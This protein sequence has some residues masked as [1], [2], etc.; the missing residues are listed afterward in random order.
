[1]PFAQDSPLLGS[2]GAQAQ[3]GQVV[4]IPH[5]RALLAVGTT[6]FIIPFGIFTWFAYRYQLVDLRVYRLAASHWWHTGELYESKYFILDHLWL[7][8]TYPPIAAILFVPTLAFRE[9]V[10]QVLYVVAT[11]GALGLTTGLFL[12]QLPVK[13]TRGSTAAILL[14]TLALTAGFE[15]LRDT[16]KL[17]QIN[18]FLML[19]VTADIMVRV[20]RWPRGLLIGLAAAIKL[21]P[22]GFVLL[23][24]VRK[25]WRTAFTIAVSTVVFTAIGWLVAPRESRLY[26]FDSLSD[27]SRIGAPY[28]VGNE[29]IRGALSRTG[30]GHAAATGCWLLLS[31][32][33][34]AVAIV[35]MRNLLARGSLIG[36]TLANAAAV[37]LISPV[38]WSHHHVWITP[39]IATLTVLTWLNGPNSRNIAVVTA[40]AIIFAIGFHKLLPAQ[41]GG[42]LGWAWWQQILGASYTFVGVAFLAWAALLPAIS[43]I[44]R[45]PS[46]PTTQ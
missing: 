13:F 18:V 41:A 9:N 2:A 32:I 4:E 12:R 7:Y 42:E 10:V 22:A 37:L 15:P 29:S 43:P 8:F 20:P 24:L 6:L 31:A 14:L 39:A 26:W 45:T 30:L 25:D 44:E 28:T 38:S 23:F 46:M 16:L 17:G 1:M 5:R 11:F 33:V 35:A 3:P 34:A 21:T 27:T 36:G 19:L 40:L